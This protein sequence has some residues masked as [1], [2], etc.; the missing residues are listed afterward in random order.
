MGCVS[1][2]GVGKVLQNT[3]LC[4]GNLG[5]I[6]RGGFLALGRVKREL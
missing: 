5:Y 4:Q 6:Y 1:G 2:D 3:K